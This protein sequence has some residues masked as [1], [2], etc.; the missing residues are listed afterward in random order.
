MTTLSYTVPT[1]GS[2]L[3]SVADPEIASALNAILTWSTAIDTNNL[4]ASANIADSQLAAP[5]SAVRKLVLQ[6]GGQVT[7]GTGG[8]YLLYPNGAILSGTLVGGSFPALWSADSGLSSQPQDFQLSGRSAYARVRAAVCVNGTAPTVNFTI[9]LYPVTSSGGAGQVALTAGTVLSGSTVA[10][11]T[12]G[13]SSVT[14]VETAQFALPTSAATYALGV[15]VS[16][17]PAANSAVGISAQ[18]YA[19]NA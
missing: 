4:S 18:L 13:A 17:A 10:V 8:I 3:N 15:N 1:A 2:T 16:G 12:P 5:A 14:G 9:G 6:A 7:G 19:Y 11:T